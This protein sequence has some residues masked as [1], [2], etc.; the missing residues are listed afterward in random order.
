MAITRWFQPFEWIKPVHSVLCGVLLLAA[1]TVGLSDDPTFKDILKSVQKRES[2]TGA[3]LT[4]AASAE[5]RAKGAPA[6]YSYFDIQIK[7]KTAQVEMYN[8]YLTGKRGEAYAFP[9]I[10]EIE[11]EYARL[12]NLARLRQLDTAV[13]DAERRRRIYVLSSF[14]LQ[15]G[16]DIKQVEA[17]LGKPVSVEYWMKAGWQT[18]VYRDVNVVTA[19]DRVHDIQSSRRE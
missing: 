1:P 17:A 15:E 13:A 9:V 7:D 2:R 10:P 11:A 4:I 8:N 3:I 14:K 18:M 16:S 6:T 5:Q 19:L 12:Q